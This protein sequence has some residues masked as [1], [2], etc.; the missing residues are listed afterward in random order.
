MSTS[1]RSLH[2]DFRPWVQALLEVARQY[3]LHPRVTSTYRS[4]K[5]Q[6]RLYERYLAGKHPYPV[7]PPG[8]SLHN[9]GMAVDLVCDDLTWLGAVWKAWGGFWSSS[10]DI[11]FA[12]RARVD[13]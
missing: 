7:A 2:P 3:G 5:S 6:A 1:L 12:A 11:H 13:W 10:D 8:R 9:Y 4:I